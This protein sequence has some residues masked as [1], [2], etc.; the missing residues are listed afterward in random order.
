L[1]TFGRAA[2]EGIALV[3]YNLDVCHA[4]G[5]GVEVLDKANAAQLFEQAAEQGLVKAQ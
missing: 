3:P 1:V 5:K 4:H 2:E